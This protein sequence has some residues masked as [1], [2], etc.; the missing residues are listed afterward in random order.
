DVG[1]TATRSAASPS[2]SK[3]KTEKPQAKPEKVEDSRCRL[4]FDKDID[5]VLVDCGHLVTC[6]SCGLKLFE[7]SMPLCPVCRQPIKRLVK[8]YKT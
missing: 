1:A 6:Y 5:C 7:D 4:C 2:T 3:T 8:T